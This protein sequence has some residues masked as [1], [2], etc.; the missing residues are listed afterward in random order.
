MRL[1]TGVEFM[2]DI[3]NGMRVHPKELT[4]GVECFLVLLWGEGLIV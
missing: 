2:V 1:E 4:L 3:G